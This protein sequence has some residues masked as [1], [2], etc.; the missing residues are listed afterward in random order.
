MFFH[1]LHNGG[2]WSGGAVTGL[3]NNP[4]AIIDF[5]KSRGLE[6]GKVVALENVF[7]PK[8]HFV[9]ERVI[10]IRFNPVTIGN[11]TINYT[12]RMCADT[13]TLKHYCSK[14][15]GKEKEIVYD[16]EESA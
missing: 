16:L 7:D 2:D 8:I 10:E 13:K 1:L 12:L 11:E 5:V 15:L 9:H 3:S 6:N 14:L 4:E